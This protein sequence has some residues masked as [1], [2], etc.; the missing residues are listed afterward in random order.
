MLTTYRRHKKDC[1]HQNE[2]REYRRCRCP[3]WLAGSIRGVKVRESLNEYDWDRAQDLAREWEAT[4]RK[5]EPPK[6]RPTIGEAAAQFVADAEARLLKGSTV[7]RHRIVFRQL[8]RFA[9]A[10]RLEYLDE[11]DTRALAKFRAG[12]TG[13]SGLAAAKKLERLRSFFKFTEAH[14]LLE[15]NPAAALGMPKIRPNPTLPFAEVEMLKILAAADEKIREAGA[16]GKNRW[17]RARALV[18]LLRYT[19]LRISDAIGCDAD[20]LVK[21]KL[22]LYTAKTGQHV[23][24]PL[25]PFV[26]AELERLPRV[27]EQHWFWNGAGK[28]E[29]SRKKWS[30]ALRDLFERAGV[31]GGHAHRFRD[32][33]AVELLKAGTPIERV[34]IFLGHASVR[35]TEKHYNPWNRARQE[36][37][38]LDVT[39]SWATDALVLMEAEAETK[40]T[41]L[42]HGKRANV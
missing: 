41:P 12:W 16:Q 19:G 20:R 27:S 23:Y 24:L 34:S 13:E 14:K 25:P 26:T 36:Q 17:R 4:A 3:I 40:G 10:E 33:F 7:D 31:A 8:A 11:L 38:E 15:G 37:A 21:G 29:T 18:L 28:L 6:I 9:A 39:R 1:A 30:E 22:F 2:G 32:T 35:I 42:V 5:P